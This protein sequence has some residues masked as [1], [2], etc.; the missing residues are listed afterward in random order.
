MSTGETVISDGKMFTHGYNQKY[1]MAEIRKII[2][3]CPQFDALLPD[4]TC[5]QTMEIFA[6]IR[7][8]PAKEVRSYVENYARSLD[9]I[10]DI[11]KRV[12]HLR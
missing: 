12:E 8:I 9:L 3:Y 11:D 2:G 7:G 1:Q 4:L 6:M 5:R 10:G